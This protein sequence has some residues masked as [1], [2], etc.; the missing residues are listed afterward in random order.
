MRLLRLIR[1][2]ANQWRS[3]GFFP[4]LRAVG[5][6]LNVRYQEWRL[7]IRSESVI[8][9]SKLGLGDANRRSYVPTD[10]R[11]FPAVLDSLNIH[12]GCDVFVDFGSGLGR[13]GLGGG[14]RGDIAAA[15]GGD[16]EERGLWAIFTGLLV[17]RLPDDRGE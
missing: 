8:E 14:G 15:G 3:E 2:F 1:T 17:E 16:A 11:T 12:A 10:Y 9:L 6:R 5:E 13:D 7:G 4:V